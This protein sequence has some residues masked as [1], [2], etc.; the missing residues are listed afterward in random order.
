MVRAGQLVVLQ[1]P[2]ARDLNVE[3]VIDMVGRSRT[4]IYRDMHAGTFPAQ[5]HLGA[6]SIGW[7]SDDIA[8]WQ[9]DRITESSSGGAS[10]E[11]A[12]ES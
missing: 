7:D 12:K 6:R 8:K 1:V 5:V 2:I 4:A 3:A 9:A 10:A 11:P